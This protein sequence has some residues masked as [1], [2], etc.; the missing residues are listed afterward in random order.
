MNHNSRGINRRK[1]DTCGKNF[2]KVVLY[3]FNFFFWLTGIAFLALGIYIKFQKHTYISL[4][5]SSTFPLSTYLLLGT[6]AFIILSGI[7]GCT[8]TCIENRCFMVMYALFLLIIFLTEAISG[9]LAYMYEGTIKEELSRNLNSTMMNN[10]HYDT[11]ITKAIDDMQKEFECCGATGFENWERSKWIQEM[12]TEDPSVKDRVP[13]SCCLSVSTDCAKFGNGPSNINP[14]GCTEA[15]EKNT[16]DSLILIGGI[17]LG[18]C[19][20]QLLGIIFSCCLVRKF[21]GRKD[22]SYL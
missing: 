3:V 15:L 19:C 2:L 7:I 17:G 14:E 21:R 1:Q 6:G 4:L 18:L 20:I 16:K 9:V 5:G 22:S 13:D 10:Y 11:V 12:I 8:G